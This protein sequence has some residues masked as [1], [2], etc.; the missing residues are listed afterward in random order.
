MQI[1]SVFAKS[2]GSEPQLK[3]KKE[4]LGWPEDER[5]P[6]QKICKYS[7]IRALLQGNFIL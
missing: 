1:S 3:G 5:G 2:I 7:R 6:W 4:I